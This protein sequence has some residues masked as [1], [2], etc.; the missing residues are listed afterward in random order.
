VGE[1]LAPS[2][3]LS[4]DGAHVPAV[5]A[6]A[7]GDDTADVLAERLAIFPDD[8]R[9]LRA[10]GVVATPWDATVGSPDLPSR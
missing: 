1:H 4:I 5:A 8:L 6:P 3:P 10:S 2:L 9:L 7:L